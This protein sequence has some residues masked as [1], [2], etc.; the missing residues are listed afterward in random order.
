MVD[1]ILIEIIPKLFLCIHLVFTR[2]LFLSFYLV[3]V[4]LYFKNI[5]FRLIQFNLSVEGENFIFA[6][7]NCFPPFIQIHI[8]GRT[9]CHRSRRKFKA[10]VM[11]M[12]SHIIWLSYLTSGSSPPLQGN[13][14][15][16]SVCRTS[17]PK[18]YSDLSSTKLIFMCTDLKRITKSSGNAL[19]IY[20][21]SIR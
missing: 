16:S 6:Q 12:Q 8:K 10:V 7:Y 15:G 17:A 9:E 18:L 4:V 19:T 13:H 14:T 11:S 1:H 2:L 3:F 21:Q 5:Y 20:L